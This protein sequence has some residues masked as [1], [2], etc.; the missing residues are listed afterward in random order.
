MRRPEGHRNRAI[1]YMDDDTCEIVC[2]CGWYSAGHPDEDACEDAWAQ[3]LGYDSLAAAEQG[4]L[5]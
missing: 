2:Q 1:N 3:H 4:W 5:R